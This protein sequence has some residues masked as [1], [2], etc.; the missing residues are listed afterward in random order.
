MNLAEQVQKAGVVGAGGAGFPTHVKLRGKADTY[1]AN[2]AECEPLLH[3]DATVMERETEQLI[4]GL[5][6]AGEAV[7][8][9]RLVIAVKEKK[10]AA[11]AAI[12]QAI[13]GTG[14]ELFLLGDYYPA[15]DEY[16]LVYTVTG[17]LIPP[18]GIPLQVGVVV[19]N[20]E[21]LLNIARAADGQPVTHKYLTVGGAVAHPVT[22]RVPIGTPIRDL[23]PLAGGTTVDDPVFFLGGLMMGPVTDDLDTPVTKT[24]T[25]VIVLSRQHPVS[26]RRMMPVEM[27]NRVGKSACDQCR[28]CTEFCPR[29]LLGYAVE[30][31]RVMRGLGFTAMGQDFWNQ[32]ALLC[33][34]CGLC[35]MYSCPEGLF[36]KEACD[37]AKARARAAGVRWEGPKE[38]HPHPMREGRRVPIQ[39]LI[40]RLHVE[41]YDQPAEFV[42]TEVQPER[43]FLPLRQWVGQPAVPQV[44]LGDQVQP[45]QLI[46]APPKDALGATLHSPIAGRVAQVDENQIVLERI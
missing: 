16:D 11:V 3:K 30:P 1:I 31:H 6:L 8:A 38:V 41:A 15:G 45:G 17:R 33:C 43:L 26:R 20:V 24:L 12:R 25:G 5:R 37:Q 39:R 9:Q 46:A 32:W 2:G 10:K 34:G 29:Y 36:P 40:R 7:G 27:K 44:R 21:S 4:R 18:M 13:Q 19:N 14:V 23:L 22:V 28:Y 42:E 35:T